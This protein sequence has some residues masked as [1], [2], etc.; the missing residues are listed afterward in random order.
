MKEE[1]DLRSVGSCPKEGFVTRADLPGGLGIHNQTQSLPQPPST[2]VVSDEK[3]SGP[4]ACSESEALPLTW[5]V[6]SSRGLIP[7][8]CNH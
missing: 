8:F 5:T 4:V 1:A 3:C 2:G 7:F 6:R